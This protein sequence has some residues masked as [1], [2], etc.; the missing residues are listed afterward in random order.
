MTFD[1]QY[2]WDYIKSG[3][4]KVFN[5]PE[6]K[7]LFG[8][9]KMKFVDDNFGQQPSFPVIYIEITD[10]YE[11]DE[12]HDSEKVENF[13]RFSFD[14]EQ[15]NQ[16]VS[17][18]TKKQLGRKIN[19]QIAE[20]IK[21]ILNPHITSNGEISSPDDTIYRRSIQGYCIINNKTKIFF[22]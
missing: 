20:T 9:K 19:M 17:P 11:P 14:I 10:F 3:L 12:F 1:E 18:L 8:G 2:V 13:T 21:D 15:Y 4:E 7:K 5:T 22:R 16:A 6:W